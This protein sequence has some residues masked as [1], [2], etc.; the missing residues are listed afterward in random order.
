MQKTA[1]LIVAGAAL[2]LSLGIPALAANKAAAP[3]SA[4][5]AE[6]LSGKIDIVE[7][8]Q[9]VVVVE[10]QDKVPYDIVITPRTRI[11]LGNQ[12]VALKDLMHYQNK[13]VT[14]RFVPEG[15]GDMASTIRISG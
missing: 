6:T 5:P 7:P 8:A 1:T 11:M 2:A 9:K 13:D 12:A 4:W 10:S 14:V 3:R 15:R